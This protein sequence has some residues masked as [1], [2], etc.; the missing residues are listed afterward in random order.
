MA[1]QRLGRLLCSRYFGGTN[2]DNGFIHHPYL[3]IF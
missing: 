3:A 1:R 2:D